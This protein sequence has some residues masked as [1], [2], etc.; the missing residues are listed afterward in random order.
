[1]P[2]KRRRYPPDAPSAVLSF[3]QFRGPV[4]DES[5]RRISHHGMNRIRPP[6]L[7]P[8]E[9]LGVNQC[10]P[11]ERPNTPNGRIDG[12]V[13]N[14]GMTVSARHGRILAPATLP[15][16]PRRA[17]GKLNNMARSA[18]PKS[19]RPRTIAVFGGYSVARNGDAYRHAHELGRSLAAAGFRLV[20]GGYDG[21]MR[22]AAQGARE[23]GG[24]TIGVTCPSAMRNGR[25]PLQPNEFLDEIIPAP[26][27]LTRIDTMMR[28]AGGYVILDGGTG[29]LTEFAIVWEH[30]SKGFL[31]PR[32]IVLTHDAWNDAVD[33]IIERKSTAARHLFRAADVTQI[34][35]HLAEHAVAI[36]S[37]RHPA[38]ALP[39]LELPGLRNDASTTIADLRRMIDRFISDRDWHQ[40]HDPK[41]LSASIA[42]EAAELMEHFQWLRSHEL[43][44][45]I[46]EPLL[47]HAVVEEIADVLA[48]LLSFAS[49]MNIDLTLA[50][51]EKLKKNEIKY[52]A[53]AFRGRAR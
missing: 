5:V 6:R 7:Q 51:T 31:P 17:A 23:N 40:F 52:P 25:T 12:I 15:D 10:I 42:I 1:M 27:L 14:C 53:A 32:P 11:A 43:N 19:K 28:R 38:P 9:C 33:A 13:V 39:A 46:R 29:T 50:L 37:P 41:N 21:T 30:I 4:L 26:D 49:A 3:R 47:R 44:A 18:R 48:Y 24:Y 2:V 16:K 45:A 36:K 20:N 8:A 35:A 22:A 34:V